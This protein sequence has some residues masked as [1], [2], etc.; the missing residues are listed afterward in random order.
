LRVLR[1]LS[2]VARLLYALRGHLMLSGRETTT[3]SLA[4]CGCRERFF[5][6][7]TATKPQEC[8]LRVQKPVGKRNPKAGKC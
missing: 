4:L 1:S 5:F 6:E 7:E 8:C 3:I 2:G